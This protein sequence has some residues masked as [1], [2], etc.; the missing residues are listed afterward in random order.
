MAVLTIPQ[1]LEK[2][3]P[4]DA[5]RSND[6]IDLINTLADDR[7]AVYF[8]ATAPTD[9]DANPLWFDTSNNLLFIYNGEW[10][11][12]S[13]SGGASITVSDNAPLSPEEGALW[14]D[15]SS[16]KSYIYYDSFWVELA[17][18][19]QGEQGIQ[20]EPG[21]TGDDGIV[22]S[23]T[24]PSNTDQLWLDTDDTAEPLVIPAG[25]TAGQILQKSTDG[26]YDTAWSNVPS[27]NYIINGAFDFWQRGTSFTSVTDNNAFLADRWRYN[28]SAETS[29]INRREFTPDELN[30]IGFGDAKYYLDFEVTTTNA[31][32]GIETPIEDVRTLAG[33]EATLSFW[34]KTVN[35][36]GLELNAGFTQHFD[37]G[38]G[39]NNGAFG[40]S[41]VLS[42]SWQRFS[43]TMT[44]PSISGKTIGGESSYYEIRFNSPLAATYDFQIWGVQL[45]AGSIAT[46]FK[47]NANSIQGELAACQ[48]YYYRINANQSAVGTGFARDSTTGRIFVPFPV[49]MRDS[50]AGLE[51]NGTASDYRIFTTNTTIACSDVPS[52]IRAN[53]VGAYIGVGVSSGLTA[54]HG[55]AFGGSVGAAAYLGW[56]VEL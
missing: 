41:V 21:A 51:Q 42:T 7:N 37:G 55:I 17:P 26:D 23:A 19:T 24:E 3:G 43:R 48:R 12:S 46:P 15:S 36:D 16:A 34:A 11:E 50:P 27:H 8:S 4:G 18:A 28:S 35:N 14:Y 38:S 33:Q 30:V 32:A 20:G 44:V 1:L 31:F 29:N 10:V 25:G 45:E 54:G 39:N 13:G 9:T 49:E 52:I 40:S 22:Q 2:F 56:D 6:Y 47:R 53:K 5:P